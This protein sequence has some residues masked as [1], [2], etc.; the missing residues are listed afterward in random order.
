MQIYAWFYKLNETRHLCK[1][2]ISKPNFPSVMQCFKEQ[3]FTFRNKFNIF[4]IGIFKAIDY[5]IFLI[6]YYFVGYQDLMSIFDLIK[7]LFT[8]MR[9]VL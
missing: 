8:I 5:C 7:L 1:Y 9:F 3:T 4:M 2:L 6:S